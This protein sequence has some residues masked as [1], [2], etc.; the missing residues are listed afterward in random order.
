MKPKHNKNH[1]SGLETAFQAICTERSIEIEY[2]TDSLSFVTSPQ[3]RRYIP[4]WTI[5]KGIYIE[6]KGRFTAA[7]RKKAI[8]VKEQ[9]PDVRIL[10][11]FQ[12]PSNTLSKQS[13]TTYGDWCDKY[14]IEWC[15]FSDID[16]W[17]DWIRKMRPKKAPAMR[18]R[19]PVA[20]API[21]KKG[22]KHQDKRST[23]KQQQKEKKE[24]NDKTSCDS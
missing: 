11:V 5:R 24:D 6:T 2:E 13:S 4:D 21:L 10:Y 7:D 16:F 17:T 14:G 8:Y 19:N 3:K 15:A 1:R 20:T 9:H 12:R 23:K 18:P 22:A